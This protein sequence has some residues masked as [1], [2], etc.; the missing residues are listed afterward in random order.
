MAIGIFFLVWDCSKIKGA[1]E[2]A[3]LNGDNRKLK[4]ITFAECHKLNR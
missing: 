4:E 2:E 3:S 1:A